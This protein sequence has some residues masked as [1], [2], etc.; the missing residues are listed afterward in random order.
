GQDRI[1]E[2]TIPIADVVKRGLGRLGG[3]II[4]IG[5]MRAAAAPDHP[6]GCT[7][8]F[9]EFNCTAVE[10]EVDR[11]TGDISIPKYVP[12][13]G[14]GKAL[15]PNQVPGQDE[16]AGGGGPGPPLLA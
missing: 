12:V 10:V 14:V 3:E 9:Y 5:E 2:R 15:N 11:E 13:S 8:W 4:G 1:D 16:G 6:L 7:A